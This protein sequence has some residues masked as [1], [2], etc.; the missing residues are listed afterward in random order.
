MVGCRSIGDHRDVGML[1]VRC[2]LGL[3]SCASPATRL[4][5]RGLH[6]A[7]PRQSLHVLPPLPPDFDPRPRGCADASVAAANK[8]R[9][10]LAIECDRVYTMTSLPSPRH[11]SRGR[12]SVCARRRE[13]QREL[14]HIAAKKSK[15]RFRGFTQTTFCGNLRNLC[16]DLC[17][18]PRHWRACCLG[19]YPVS[20]PVCYLTI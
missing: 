14:C 4:S 2:H 9:F 1:V 5:S 15:R 6:L 18:S 17:E 8:I 7:R 3:H 12:R 11:I 16:F 10:A 20:Y 13:F 19:C